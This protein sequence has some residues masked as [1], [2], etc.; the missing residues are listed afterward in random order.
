MAQMPISP[1]LAKVGRK[2]QA[3]AVSVSVMVDIF[4]VKVVPRSVDRHINPASWSVANMALPSP[5][6]LSRT[7]VSVTPGVA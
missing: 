4:F 7:S 3:R 2:A 1:S 5:R 6:M